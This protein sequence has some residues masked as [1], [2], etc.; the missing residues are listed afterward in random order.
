MHTTSLW[1]A[2]GLNS[3]P[4]LS[5]YNYHL[6]SPHELQR[7]E[8]LSQYYGPSYNTPPIHGRDFAPPGAGYANLVVKN[9]YD[10]ATQA[11][12]Q[13]DQQLEMNRRHRRNAAELFHLRPI[14]RY[15]DPGSIST[16]AAASRHRL[17]QRYMGGG[18]YDHS[19]D[20]RSDMT[21]GSMNDVNDYYTGQADMRTADSVMQTEAW[22]QDRRRQAERLIHS[23]QR[24]R[25]G[26][27]GEC[28]S[29]GSGPSSF[30]Y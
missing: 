22:Q 19:M 16:Q 5:A 29:C 14:P 18:Y 15:G 21:Q 27:G 12:M 4:G 30:S 10:A 9:R 26:S 2:F 13:R 24:E 25:G 7:L 20:I 1:K 28:P 8:G 17:E 3:E 11:A 6:A 23:R